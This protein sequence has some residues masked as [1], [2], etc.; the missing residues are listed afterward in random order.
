M[1]AEINKAIR[2]ATEDF[3]LCPNRI[4]AHYDHGDC[5]IDFCEYSRHDLTSVKQRHVSALCQRNLCDTIKNLF[6]RALLDKAALDDLPTAWR[7][8][9]KS[10][11]ESP[12]PFM[13]ISHM[14]S[15]GTGAGAWPEGEVNKCLYRFFMEIAQ[16]YQ[17]QGIWWDTICMPKDK[18]ARTKAINKI[19]RNHENARITLT[20]CLAILLSPWFSRGWTA[21][22][23]AHSRKV[24]VLFK[25]MIIQD[26]NEDILSNDSQSN[27]D[28]YQFASTAIRCLRNKEVTS[29][30]DLLTVLGHRR[31]S[32]N[33]ERSIMAIYFTDQ[34]Q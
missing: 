16:R 23:L 26:L 15:D 24:K 5:T 27:S 25:G 4:V 19:Q 33:S 14:W 29:V 20:A 11:I 10:M 32:Y 18:A 34:Q 1:A 6:P 7:L 31:L 13:A 12:E 2:R 21:L 30:N 3:Q 9:G 28:P 22:E 8:D 17:C